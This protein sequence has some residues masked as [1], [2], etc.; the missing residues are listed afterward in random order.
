M[1]YSSTTNIDRCNALPDGHQMGSASMH[2]VIAGMWQ[3]WYG[4]M[5]ASIWHAGFMEQWY[6]GR[7]PCHRPY[8]WW[9][10]ETQ[11]I[12]KRHSKPCAGHLAL[13][14]QLRDASMLCIHCNSSPA[15]FSRFCVKIPA[16]TFGATFDWTSHSSFNAHV[17][18]NVGQEMGHSSI[19]A[20]LKGLVL[21]WS[22]NVLLSPI[23]WC[24]T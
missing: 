2:R 22:Q 14:W 3:F 16:H 5:L 13:A 11:T 4:N 21:L 9:Y 1:N 12:K 7:N 17:L 18:H 23:P 8:T 15:K 24:N 20:D 10:Q 6:C 19:L